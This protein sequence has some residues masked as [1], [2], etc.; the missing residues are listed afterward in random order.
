MPYAPKGAMRIKSRKA[1]PAVKL[2]TGNHY[3]YI[4]ENN[5]KELPMTFPEPSRMV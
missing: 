4:K 1:V 2:P 3:G 5:C